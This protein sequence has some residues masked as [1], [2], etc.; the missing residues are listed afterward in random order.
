MPPEHEPRK[1]QSNWRLR[2]PCVSS[3][4]IGLTARRDLCVRIVLDLVKDEGAPQSV[5]ECFETVVLLS[6][7]FHE[8]GFVGLESKY[9]WP[10]KL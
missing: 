6:C 9:H 4:D 8:L 5:R 2:I 7:T 1:L 10:D 3:R